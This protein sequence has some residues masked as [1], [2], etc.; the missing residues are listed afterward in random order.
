MNV[1][2]IHHDH[3]H[4]E[5]SLADPS[6]Y[7]SDTSMSRSPC[8]NTHLDKILGQVEDLGCG[9][10]HGAATPPMAP[11][12]LNPRMYLPDP[13][14]IMTMAVLGLFPSR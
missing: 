1:L 13:L 2:L 11:L 14:G 9:R 12:A 10:T 8:M 7:K 4:L 3:E 5:L 6:E